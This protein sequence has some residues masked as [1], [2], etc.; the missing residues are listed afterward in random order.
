[1]SGWKRFSLLRWRKALNDNGPVIIFGD[2]AAAAGSSA[3][4]KTK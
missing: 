3:S 1:M 2:L 4:K